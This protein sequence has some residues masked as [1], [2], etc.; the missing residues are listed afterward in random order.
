MTSL[1]GI[2]SPSPHPS[3]E[4]VSNDPIS[5]RRDHDFDRLAYAYGKHKLKPGTSNLTL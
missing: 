4:Q 5:T 3:M 1:C 2:L